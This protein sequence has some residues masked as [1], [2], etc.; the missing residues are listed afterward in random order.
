M[1]ASWNGG[2]KSYSFTEGESRF[3]ILLEDFRMERYPATDHPI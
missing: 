1:V 2:T 3:E